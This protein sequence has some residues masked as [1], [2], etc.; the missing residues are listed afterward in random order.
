MAGHRR[1]GSKR[2]A[3][4]AHATAHHGKR[5]PAHHPKPKKAPKAKKVRM[6]TH[7]GHVI[8]EKP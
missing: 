7:R 6:G 8:V 2:G 3:K 5:A 1:H 4:A